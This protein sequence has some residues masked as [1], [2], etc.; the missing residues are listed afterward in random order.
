MQRVG[1]AASSWSRADALTGSRIVVLRPLG[2]CAN[3][4]SGHASVSGPNGHANSC[5]WP[6]NSHVALNARATSGS[7]ATEKGSPLA[8]MT[9]TIGFCSPL[10]STAAPS[11]PIE[12]ESVSERVVVHL[13]KKEG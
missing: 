8:C 11:A 6:A 13:R 1:H 12:N 2:S 4:A 9:K 3:C 7:S 10:T 5:V